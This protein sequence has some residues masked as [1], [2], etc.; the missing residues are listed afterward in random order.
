MNGL[1]RRKE[2]IM[3]HFDNNESN[4]H[5]YSKVVLRNWIRSFPDRFGIIDL[6][7][8]R[9]EECFAENGR[10]IF[11]PD[12]S[13]YDRNGLTHMFEIE[14]TSPLTGEKLNRMQWYFFNNK[15]NPIIYEIEAKYI[16]KQT[17]CPTKIE[18]QRFELFNDG[19]KF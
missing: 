13:V 9:L 1:N 7:S 10:I 18:M 14:H 19:I 11:V 15:E 4:L 6:Q 5:F 16:M 3:Y 12:V 17:K 8:V 2:M